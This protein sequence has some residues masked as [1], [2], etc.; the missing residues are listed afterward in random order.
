[1]HC[2]H[3]QKYFVLSNGKNCKGSPLYEERQKEVP[4]TAEVYSIFITEDEFIKYLLAYIARI[5]HYQ[6]E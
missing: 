2:T 6:I 5:M 4:Q 3:T 1:L